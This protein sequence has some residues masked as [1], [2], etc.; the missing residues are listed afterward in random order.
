MG[1]LN[2]TPIANRIH[3]GFFGKRNS[4]K[5]SLLNALSNQSLS[6]VSSIPG[7]TTDPVYKTMEIHG[8]GPCVLIDTAGFDDVGQLGEMRIEKTKQAAKKTDIAVLLFSDKNLSEELN[9]YNYFKKNNTPVICAVS[10]SDIISN[11]NDLL[12]T[13]KNNNIP[14]PICINIYEKNSIEKLKYALIKSIP[15]NY[16]NKSITS[17]LINQNDVVLLVMPQDIQAPQGRLIL[18]QVQTIRDLLDN[19]CIVMCCT[20]DKLDLAISSLSKPPKLIITDSQVF[21]TVYQK[22]PKESLLTSFSI[23]FAAYKG[24]LEYYIKSARIIDSLNN[25]SKILIAECCTHAPLSEDIG[26]EKL[27]KLLRTKIHPS[28]TIDIVS[29]NDFPDNLK[30]YDLIIQ[31]G[32]CMFNRKHV[33][34]R[35]NIAKSQNVPMSNYGVVFAYLN[36]ILDKI[37]IKY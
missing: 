29:G 21:K 8:I 31:C 18:P 23:L 28:I 13:I 25:N 3:I 2:D 12:S 33:L 26:R 6:I 20:T 5:S 4:G 24:D 9:W 22:K 1:S 37:S 16:S 27:P 19:K 14:S 34:S 35:I 7:T 36:G 30:D 32:A 11:L 15:E 17:K 10:K